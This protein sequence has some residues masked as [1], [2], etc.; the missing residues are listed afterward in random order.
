VRIYAADRLAKRGSA[1]QPFG[2]FQRTSS[3]RV[4][5]LPGDQVLVGGPLG[6]HLRRRLR[7]HS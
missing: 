5:Q 1:P 6:R 7:W 4:L 2:T 3:L